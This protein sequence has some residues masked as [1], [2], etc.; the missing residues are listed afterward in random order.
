MNIAVNLFG[1]IAALIVLW[2]MYLQVQDA[3]KNF[4]DSL[5]KFGLGSK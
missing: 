4:N 1:W 2:L 3:N 5:D